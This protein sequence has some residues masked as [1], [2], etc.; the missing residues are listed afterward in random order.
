MIND[1]Q[2]DATIKEIFQKLFKISQDEVDD[3][4]RRGHLETW[5]SLGHLDLVEALRG[6]FGLDISPERALDME[7]VKDIKRAVRELT[8][9]D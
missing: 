6:E 5:D 2:L 7:T 3:E 8:R 4:T 1:D 9:T